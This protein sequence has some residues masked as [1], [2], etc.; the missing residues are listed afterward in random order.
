MILSISTSSQ[1]IAASLPPSSRVTRFS[2]FAQLAMTLRPVTDDPVKLILS[3]P[4]CSVI[5]GPRSSPPLRAWTTPGG[6]WGIA[7]SASFKSQ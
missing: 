7:S 5:R 3:M 2:V 6:K 4:G 1:I